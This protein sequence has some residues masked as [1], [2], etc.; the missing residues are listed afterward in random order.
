MVSTCP[1]PSP[2][3]RLHLH[4]DVGCTRC[5]TSEVQSEVREHAVAITRSSP[6]GC[7]TG[8]DSLR[9]PPSVMRYSSNVAILFREQWAS[10]HPATYHKRSRLR[11]RIS[12]R[13]EERRTHV[14]PLRRR[15]RALVAFCPEHVCLMSGHPAPAARTREQQVVVVHLVQASAS[16]KKRMVLQLRSR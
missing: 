12:G 10:P 3:R 7:R 8:S 1:L 2:A 6:G 11:L 4:G 16:R 14:A 13:V 5:A 9:A 15:E